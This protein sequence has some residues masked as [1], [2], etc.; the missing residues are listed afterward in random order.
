MARNDS[1]TRIVWHMSDDGMRP[2]RAPH[3]FIARNPVVRVLRPRESARIDLGVAASCPLL[4]YPVGSHAKDL[5]T[6]AG[7]VPAGQ[8][9]IVTVNNDSTLVDLIIETGEGL[10]NLVPLLLPPNLEVEFE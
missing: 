3:W 6:P 9:V 1:P 7:I 2:T 4:V 10:V 5:V 8:E